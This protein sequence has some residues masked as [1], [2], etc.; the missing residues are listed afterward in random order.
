MYTEQL[1]LSILTTHFPC[2]IDPSKCPYEDCNTQ[3]CIALLQSHSMQYIMN[4]TI[5]NNKKSH[6]KEKT[7]NRLWGEI[8]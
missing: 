7:L 2:I 5:N 8:N 1:M 3:E 6:K 4:D